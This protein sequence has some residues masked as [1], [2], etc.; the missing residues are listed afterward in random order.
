MIG[1]ARRAPASQNGHESRPKPV[2]GSS[3][4]PQRSKIGPKSLVLKD[5]TR[6][7]FKLKELAGIS[8]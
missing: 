3:L 1:A 5:F 2:L 8:S 7:S 4:T 6:K